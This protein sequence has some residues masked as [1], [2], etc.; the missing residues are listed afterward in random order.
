MEGRGEKGDRKRG[1][2]IPAQLGRH[3][4]ATTTLRLKSLTRTHR[5]QPPE[6]SSV[7]PAMAARVA[8]SMVFWVNVNAWESTCEG[9][10]VK[11]G[12]RE[13]GELAG[14]PS[15]R[16]MPDP[17]RWQRAERAR[18]LGR[19]SAVSGT[20]NPTSCRSR[21]NVGVALHNTATPSCQTA[22]ARTWP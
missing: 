19:R 2:R 22:A 11:G 16:S 6:T 21:S 5:L 14:S 12:K 17:C 18:A 3:G 8:G 13:I 1:R 10:G 9:A 15:G 4:R 20:C 7:A